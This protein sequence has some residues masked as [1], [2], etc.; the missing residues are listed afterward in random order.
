MAQITLDLSGK[1]GLDDKA[2]GKG[3]FLSGQ[4]HRILSDNNK[5]AGGIFNPFLVD[6]YLC[7]AQNSTTSV[8]TP[9]TLTTNIGSSL[10]EIDTNKSFF[11]ERGNRIYRGDG[12]ED[13]SLTTYQ[14]L[15]TG[16]VVNDLES[17]LI[18]GG[19]S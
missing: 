19:V 5:M 17:Y 2:F 10:Y 4:P 18:D 7:P 8:T 14:T 11:G 9:P 16:H 15:T 6:G 12:L 1:S 13:T 3:S